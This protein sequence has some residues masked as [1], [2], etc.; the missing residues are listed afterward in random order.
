LPVSRAELREQLLRLLMEDEEFRY[1]V[2]GIL[3]YLD[4][5][6][7]LEEHD[8][9]FNE[10]LAEIRQLREEFNRVDKVLAELL[11]GQERLWREFNRLNARV[12]VTIGSMGRRWGEDLERMVLEIFREALEKRGIEPGKVRKLRLRDE[13]GSLTGVKGRVVD[14]DV[15][16]EDEKVYVIEVKSRAELEHV[17]ALP[18]KSQVVGKVLGKQVARTILVAVN[19]DR[20]AYERAGELGIEVVCGHVIE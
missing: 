11:K 2:A 1:T 12:E 8:R 14:V 3:G 7:R 13:D 18:L 20:E 4:V 16:V 15:L 10:I 19:V 6:K 5:L 17:E 9:K